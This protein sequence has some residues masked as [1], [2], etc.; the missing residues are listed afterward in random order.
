MPLKYI[1]GIL[2]IFVLLRRQVVDA[3]PII[4]E[5]ILSKYSKASGIERGFRQ[6]F[7]FRSQR[8]RS[9]FDMDPPS[10]SVLFMYLLYVN[11]I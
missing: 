9:I 11:E 10:V 7:K 6:C 8:K 4:F 5:Q 3:T 2:P 1:I